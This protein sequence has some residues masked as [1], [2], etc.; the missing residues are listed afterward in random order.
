M[1][2]YI[3]SDIKYQTTTTFQIKNKTEIF[4]HR[5]PAKKQQITSKKL[6]KIMKKNSG[7]YLRFK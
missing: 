2:S 6:L 1:C 5:E 7:P 3:R 4:S